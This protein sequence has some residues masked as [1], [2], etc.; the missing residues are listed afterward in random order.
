MTPVEIRTT[1]HP[2]V[3][4]DTP[5]R[6]CVSANRAPRSPPHDGL[7]GGERRDDLNLARRFADAGGMFSGTPCLHALLT[8]P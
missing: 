7:Q 2:I 5:S 1:A 4:R 6:K 8:L 3:A